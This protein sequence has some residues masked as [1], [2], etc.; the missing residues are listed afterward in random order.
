MIPIILN[1]SSYIVSI[2][3]QQTG[4]TAIFWQVLQNMDKPKYGI[5]NY[6][7]LEKVAHVFHMAELWNQAKKYYELLKEK[8]PSEELC[9]CVNDMD[10]NGVMS[11]LQLLALKIK[12]P[13]L[14]SGKLLS[15]QDTN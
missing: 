6:S 12:Y 11:E 14:T 7:T 4:Y 5:I 15:A 8:S 13:G 1:L 9:G 3:V 2:K 10:E